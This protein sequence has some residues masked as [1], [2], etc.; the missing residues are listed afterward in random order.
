MVYF[1]TNK[2]GKY[3]KIGYTKRKNINTRIKEL[4]TGS[5]SPLYVLGCIKDGDMQLEKELHKKFKQVN[6][7]W[8]EADNELLDYINTNN[9]VMV[10]VGWLDG[11]LMTY[12][13][14]KR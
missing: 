12:Q 11:K 10:Y 1:L 9:D 13:K 8:F 4:S 14:M 7:E 6:L 2:E 3:I 5:S